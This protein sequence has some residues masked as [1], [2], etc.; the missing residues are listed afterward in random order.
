MM[1]WLIGIK[2]VSQP[3]IHVSLKHILWC[4]AIRKSNHH[5]IYYL[6]NELF[7]YQIWYFYNKRAIMK[8]YPITLHTSSQLFDQMNIRYRITNSTTKW[9]YQ[10][11]KSVR[12]QINLYKSTCQSV[13]QSKY[14]NCIYD[15]KLIHEKYYRQ[16][17]SIAINLQ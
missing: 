2:L 15:I 4:F 7:Q 11:N 14:F 12:H 16:F 5:M 10:R 3:I 1:N 8:K 9:V 13:N 6:K 17:S